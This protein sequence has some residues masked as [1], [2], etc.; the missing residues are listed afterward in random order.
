MNNVILPLHLSGAAL[1]R[2]HNILYIVLPKCGN[3]SM[4][5]MMVELEGDADFAGFDIDSIDVHTHKNKTV[6]QNDF[7]KN[8][9]HLRAFSEKLFV[10]TVVRNPYVRVLSGYLDKIRNSPD[11][12][13]TWFGQ[14][15]SA[16]NRQLSFVEFLHLLKQSDLNTID[17]HLRPAHLVAQ[18]GLVRYDYIG[19]LEEVDRVA[20]AINAA[21][22]CDIRQA[23]YCSRRIHSSSKRL[24][25]YYD[26]E[27]VELVDEIFASDF[28]YFNYP[29]GDFE[30]LA[31]GHID[32]DRVNAPAK[33]AMLGFRPRK[34][35]EENMDA[36]LLM[37]QSLQ[38]RLSGDLPAALRENE[39]AIAL[40]S[41]NPYFFAFLGDLLDGAGNHAEAADALTKAIA[42]A[43]LD[44]RLHLQLGVIHAHLDDARSATRAV[45]AAIAT[46]DYHHEFYS[47][48]FNVLISIFDL[49]GTEEVLQ[50]AIGHDPDNPHF[51][52]LRSRIHDHFGQSET[53]IELAR[54]AMGVV[55]YHPGLHMHLATMHAARNEFTK[56]AEVL[57][58]AI[59]HNPQSSA[60]RLRL[61]RL[62]LQQ[63]ET[64]S[65][66][67]MAREA[68]ATKDFY[69]GFYQHLTAL[70]NDCCTLEEFE[71]E[72]RQAI[73]LNEG[74]A[75]FLLQL[76]HV[77]RRQNKI[78]E[79]VLAVREAIRNDSLYP[80]F[81]YHLT[82]L[83]L[84][85]GDPEGARESAQKALTLVPDDPGVFHALLGKTYSALGDTKAA[86]EERGKSLEKVK[87]PANFDEYF[88]SLFRGLPA[89][90]TSSATG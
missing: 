71:D 18:T 19:K 31:G 43:P 81:Y 89:K 40:V 1:S 9:E 55:N 49:Q 90:G 7:R 38:H 56:A 35:F 6:I 70:L 65:A 57:K 37:E 11:P 54:E 2:Y 3:T 13:A 88:A 25:G 51:H 29:K 76:S 27:A 15:Y 30:N 64:G 74:N 44:S 73:A 75:H 80:G 10:F 82:N 33:D 87:R 50:Q 86:A 69:I 23:P 41:D 67:H 36:F 16:K 72:L 85:S 5:R 14:K 83:L 53:A 12:R 59:S 79:A 32:I 8:I 20:E 63:G 39:Q 84:D 24:F 62:Y 46:K 78:D 48:L 26:S 34:R 28:V 68:I 21:R 52:L 4:K 61:G 66:L 45:L 42:L 58:E 77:H 22:H 47:A 17:W 60:I